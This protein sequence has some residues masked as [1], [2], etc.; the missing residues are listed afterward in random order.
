MLDELNDLALLR[1]RDEARALLKTAV[2]AMVETERPARLA[3]VALLAGGHLLVED[4]PGVG[5]TTLARI[6]SRAIGGHDSRI[7]C[8]PDL[9]PSDVLGRMV[10][11]DRAGEPPE[12][13]EPGPIFANAVVLD[14]INRATTRLQSALFEAME[15]K[16]VSLAGRRHVL[17]KPFFVVATMNPFGGEHEH[18]RLSHG[19]RDRFAISTGIGYPSVRGERELLRR[20]G[21][22]DIAAQVDPIVATGDVVRLQ[23]TVDRVEVPDPVLDYLVD[24][25]RATRQHPEVLVGASPRAALSLQRCAQALALLEDTRTVTP[26]Q[27]TELVAPCLAH[28]L[29]VRGTFSPTLVCDE[30]I[31]SVRAPSWSGPQRGDL[32]LGRVDL[33]TLGQAGDAPSVSS[34]ELR[35]LER[36]RRGEHLSA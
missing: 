36:L 5:K 27:V 31:A 9:G 18:A 4:V 19:Q 30:V 3:L 12:S 14:E 8:T 28:R 22:Y 13:F 25:V 34:L 7:Q 15:E 1:A 17:P 21:R 10:R 2:G 20:F 33:P 6:V 32:D 16:F 23:Q 24:L 29:E 35:V 26:E 11:T